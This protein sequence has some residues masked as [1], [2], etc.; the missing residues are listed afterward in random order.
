MKVTAVAVSG[1]AINGLSDVLLLTAPAVFAL[2]ILGLLLL[3]F[4][5]S[6]SSSLSLPGRINVDL[7]KFSLVSLQLGAVI[8]ACSVIPLLPARRVALPPAGFAGAASELYV[9]SYEIVAVAILTS[10]AALAALRR[11]AVVDWLV[12]LAA[13]IA[14]MTLSLTYFKSADNDPV[15]TFVGWLAASAGLTLTLTL[16]PEAVRLFRDFLGPARTTLTDSTAAAGPGPCDSLADAASRDSPQVPH[17]RR[18]DSL[19]GGDKQ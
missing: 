7:L 4:A 16:L 15:T 14:G 10:L 6:P 2:S 13:S 11:R 3:L 8:G 18:D 19:D 17:G 5:E 12:F 9:Y 1:L